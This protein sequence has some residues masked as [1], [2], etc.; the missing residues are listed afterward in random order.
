MSSFLF[1]VVYIEGSKNVVI[2]ALLRM[3]SRDSSVTQHSRSEFTYHDVVD[4]DMSAV[5]SDLD[6][7]PLLSGIEALV[8]TC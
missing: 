3:Y 4:D 2:D 1:K 8:A 5:H 7:L 6:V